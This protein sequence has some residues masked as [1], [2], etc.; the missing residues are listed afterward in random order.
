M[1]T[2]LA[3]GLFGTWTWV[4]AIIRINIIVLTPFEG[5]T[6]ALSAAVIAFGTVASFSPSRRRP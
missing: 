3:A 4:D 6:L 5:V 1:G 2:F